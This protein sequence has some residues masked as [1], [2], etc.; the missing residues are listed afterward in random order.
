M[1]RFCYSLILYLLSPLIIF[2]LY[3]IR[4]KKN[5]AYRH[6]F[7]ERF[8]F[9]KANKASP[10]LIHCASVGEVLAATPLIKQLQSQHPELAI[11]IT[12]NTPTGRE[13]IKNNFKDSVQALYLPLDLPLATARFLKN[14][15]PQALCILETELWPN[16]MAQCLNKDIPVLVLNARLSAKSQQGYNKI[17]PLT[18]VIMSSITR[19]ASHNQQDAQR[20]IELGLT[21]D[22]V[23][24]T[25]SIKFDIQP[26]TEQ[27]KT[28]SELKALYNQ[29]RFIWVAGSTH[30]IEHGLILQVHSHL[31]T[32][33]PDA[34]LVI[35][36][37]HPEQFNK[38][39]DLLTDSSLTF[40]RR[41]E[42]NYANE[43]VLLA[44][45][46]GEL[47][48][49]YGMAKVSYIG[50]S[51]I[52]RGG[53]NPLEAA[54]FSVGAIAGPHTYNFNHVYPELIALGGCIQVKSSDELYKQL[55][56]YANK[57]QLCEAL[58]IQAN[59]CLMSNQ[60]AIANTLTIINQ[61]IKS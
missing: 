43:Q 38:V 56:L 6:Q 25:G 23:V 14:I 51:L 17:K 47:Q 28:V 15:Q 40:S 48:C 52:E 39:A 42:G 33:F 30:P 16:L 22:K 57:P 53:H 24:V 44:D 12:C 1:A 32:Q 54:A 26:N 27:L 46:L 31:L 7:T 5:Q 61:Y 8:G 55:C 13:Q 58:G 36:P 45:T 9:V 11:I 20:F 49:L 10:L 19:L 18:R 29:Q 59:K 50:G 21:P 41:S 35:A 37:R 2:Y 34:L 4:G 3:A 60:G